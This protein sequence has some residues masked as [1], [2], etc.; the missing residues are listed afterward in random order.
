MRKNNNNQFTFSL[1]SNNK[2]FKFNS[3][4]TLTFQSQKIINFFSMINYKNEANQKENYN[5]NL[6]MLIF[7]LCQNRLIQFQRIKNPKTYKEELEES[8]NNCNLNTDDFLKYKFFLNSKNNDI[9]Y[10]LLTKK[11]IFLGK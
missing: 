1:S 9:C 11:K 2:H 3:F 10:I 5:E 7:L 8:K 6:K 4:K